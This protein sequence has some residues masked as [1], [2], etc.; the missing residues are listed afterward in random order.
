MNILDR[1]AGARLTLFVTSTAALAL[2]ACSTT[3]FAPPE[4][5]PHRVIDKG[6]MF[7]CNQLDTSGERLIDR[8]VL[9]SIDL[10]DN[11]IRAY[12]CASHEAADGRQI[13]EVPSMLG[14]IAAGVGPAFGL[15]PDGALAAATGATVYGRANNYYAPKEKAAVID[16]A[17]DA[18]LCAKAATL[19]FDFFDTHDAPPKDDQVE[20]QAGVVSDLTADQRA[21]DAG[22]AKVSEGK[23]LP[24]DQRQALSA[25]VTDKIGSAAVNKTTLDQ[26]SKR[27][28]QEVEAAKETLASLRSSISAPRRHFEMV[29]TA[30]F[31][32]E[33][34]LAQRLSNIGNFDSA[35]IAAEFARLG[36]VE[37]EAKEEKKDIDT[38]QSLIKNGKALTP[39]TGAFEKA[40]LEAELA[41]MNARL[42][43]CV[44]RAK[45]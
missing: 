10:I 20:A 11:F 36:G 19:G 39:G 27:N 23:A 43:I 17:L 6:R 33:R 44:V 28:Q 34:V 31:A 37:E 2:S 3:S 29:S 8:D 41:L 1:G 18:V 15:S 32:I 13:F 5:Q 7:S 16:T 25:L 21:L 4:V 24:A 30:L 9:G 42:Q 45:V 12:R 22:L 40:Q 35:G 14:L 38:G 26:A